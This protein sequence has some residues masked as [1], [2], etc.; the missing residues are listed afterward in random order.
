MRFIRATRNRATLLVVGLLTLAA[1]AWLGAT[2]LD[3]GAR[4]ATASALPD[5]G[6]TV[7]ELVAPEQPWLL[8]LAG[9]L[10][11]VAVLAGLGLLVAQV[12]TRPTAVP[13]RFGDDDGTLHASVGTAVVERA[14]AEH[15]EATPGV[16]DADVHLRG[17]ARDVWVQA[18]VTVASE[19][20]VAWAVDG[21][22]RVL[23]DDLEVALGAAPRRLD[24]LVHLRAGARPSRAVAQ[25]GGPRHDAPASGREVVP[26]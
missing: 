18:E 16:L 17:T 4:W 26:A 23:A 11:V 9:A 5:P 8:P 3:V 21:A 24:V 25:V 6:S 10:A 13:L 12:P 7:G 15:L 19:S 2:Q 22:R 1:A 20:E 14:L